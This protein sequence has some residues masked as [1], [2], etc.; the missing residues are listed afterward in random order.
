MAS[1]EVDQ[2][3]ERNERNEGEVPKQRIV[4]LPP[5]RT[6]GPLFPSG[7]SAPEAAMAGATAG[8]SDEELSKIDELRTE[9]GVEE[10]D[11]PT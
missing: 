6:A 11:A 8:M 1:K 5:E 4:R 3:D 2:R 10:T 9:Y 7:M